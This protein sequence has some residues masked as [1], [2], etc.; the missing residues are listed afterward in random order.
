MPPVG[1][2]D[3]DQDAFAALLELADQEDSCASR[4]LPA[5]RPPTSQDK[6]EVATGQPSQDSKK[7]GRHESRSDAAVRRP[8]KKRRSFTDSK[9]NDCSATNTAVQ[10]RPQH[11][12]KQTAAFTS[13]LTKDERN[14]ADGRTA[15]QAFNKKHASAPT[16]EKF[17]GLRVS[18]HA[19]RCSA[20]Q[21]CSAYLCHVPRRSHHAVW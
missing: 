16:Q 19:S 5:V 12:Q 14:A 13:A 4:D 7:K 1:C 6:S 18:P 2:V 20:S 9:E 21:A 3:G 8:Q 10:A 15:Q 11:A 17:S